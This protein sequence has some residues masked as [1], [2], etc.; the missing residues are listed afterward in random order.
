VSIMLAG[1][2]I[3]VLGG[4]GRRRQKAVQDMLCI[5]TLRRVIQRVVSRVRCVKVVGATSSKCCLVYR[6][7]ALSDAK[8]D[9]S[10]RSFYRAANAIFGRVGNCF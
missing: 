7:N 10:R 6:T 4:D 2:Q 5:C 9:Q 8:A 1:S 3:V